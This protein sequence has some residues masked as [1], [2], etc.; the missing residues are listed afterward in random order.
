M[1]R[2]KITYRGGQWYRDYIKTGEDFDSYA[3][4]R[5]SE[6]QQKSPDWRPQKKFYQSLVISYL[7]RLDDLNNTD[8]AYQIAQK[9]RPQ[10]NHASP[11]KLLNAWRDGD[12][13]DLAFLAEVYERTI[14][15]GLDDRWRGLVM[16]RRINSGL[17]P[18]DAA[19]HLAE[20]SGS[21]D[22]YGERVD[23]VP[24]SHFLQSW[25]RL[26]EMLASEMLSKI[27]EGFSA[28]EAAH[29]LAQTSDKNISASSYLDAF[30]FVNNSKS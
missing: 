29:F 1:T 28:E 13:G 3:C 12:R 23:R 27:E 15:R 17:T 22:K 30:D 21:L 20:E 6:I 9:G 11:S 8:Y 19:A 5:I 2:Q 7:E 4:A 26:H 10:R 16:Q 25:R 18:Y 24:P 14:I